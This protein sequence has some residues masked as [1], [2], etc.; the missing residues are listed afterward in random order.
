MVSFKLHPLVAGALLAVLASANVNI[1][2]IPY[3]ASSKPVAKIAGSGTALKSLTT[4]SDLVPLTVVESP[5]GAFTSAVFDGIVQNYTASDDV[6][7]TGFLQVVYVKANGSVTLPKVSGNSTT[8]VFLQ[9]S[10]NACSASLPK[11]PYFLSVSTGEVYQAYRLYSD[12]QGAFTEGVVENGDGTFDV[13]SAA[14]SGAQS[15]TIGV[16]SRLYYTKSAEKPLA[17]V[18]LGV[19]DIY[20]IAGLKTSCGNRAY[21]DLYSKQNATGTAVQRLIDAGA[22][23]VGKMKT[24]QF[25][26]GET[27]TADWVDYHSPFNA[28]GDGY[29]DPSSSSSGPGAGIGAYPWLD[30]GL[31]SDTGGSIRNP[32]QVNGCFGNRPSHGLVPLDSVMPMS[33][34][35]DTSGFL[36]RDAE[37]WK[38]TA[39]ALYQENVTFWEN[40]PAKIYTSGFPT[41]ASTEAEV[42]LL[43]FLDQLKTFL[44]ATVTELDY[45]ALWNATDLAAS[46]GNLSTFLGYVYPTLIAQQQYNQFTLP[47]YADY[48]KA[49]NGR[50]PFIDPSPLSRW[51]WGQV[52]MSASATD[53]AIA[54]K[55]IFM[56][57]WTS[58][59]LVRDNATCSDS[60]MLYPGTLATPTYRN[61]YRSA[62]GI[63]SGFSVSRIS[64]FAEVP[65]MVVPIGQAAY[66]S[67]I[68]LQSEYLPVA[69]DILAAK[70]CDGMIFSLVEKLQSAG[71]VKAVGTGSTMYAGEDEIL[72]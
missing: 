34:V 68:T 45:N 3:H 10:K 8:S 4:T 69:V 24:S 17:G 43:S 35:L 14:I 15:P 53:E 54:N 22:V 52:N 5:S 13:L 16:L 37:L 58:E 25:A 49:F 12:I 63:P 62:P 61:V 64:N 51:T 26:N 9:S 23:I 44:S 40:Y 50:K 71:I 31:G 39:K 28:R 72:M 36:C 57:W 1:N 70:G 42:V 38:T 46:H 18:R 19:K 20:H 59:V 60:I 21:Y 11:G 55:T 47:F 7:T 33:P 56:D 66:N 6:F 27:A 32:S 2:G 48:A 67:T 30:L 41:E 65:D 29:Q